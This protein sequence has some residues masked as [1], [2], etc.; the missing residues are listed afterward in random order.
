MGLESGKTSGEYYDKVAVVFL[1][2]EDMGELRLEENASVKVSTR[3][4]SVVVRCRRGELDRGKAFMP[5]GPWA[6]SVVGTDTG[7]TGMPLAKGIE[8]EIS[9]TEEKPTSLEELIAKVRG[10]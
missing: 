7:G 8:A 9:K 5:F 3:F 1:N 10:V 4:G 2:E 6:S